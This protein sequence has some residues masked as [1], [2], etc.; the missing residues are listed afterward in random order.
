MIAWIYLLVK[1]LTMKQT[2]AWITLLQP[3]GSWYQYED[4]SSSPELCPVSKDVAVPYVPVV[5][6]LLGVIQILHTVVFLAWTDCQKAF[7]FY[8]NRF[9]QQFCHNFSVRDLINGRVVHFA[10][11]RNSF[12]TDI[13]HDVARSD[14]R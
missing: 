11:E 13:I 5:G 10:D 9:L 1:I 12:S 14:I 2:F 8:V 3:F 6:I 7:L 4:C